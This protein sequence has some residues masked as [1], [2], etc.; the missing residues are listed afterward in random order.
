MKRLLFLVVMV[1]VFQSRVAA[2][3]GGQRSGGNEIVLTGESTLADY[4]SYAALHN[5]GLEAAFE[6]W[7]AA[8][9]VIPQAGA[10]PDPRFTF[11]Y[12]IQEVETRVGPQQRS[13]AV[14]QT[15]PWLGKLKSRGDAAARAADAAEQRYEAARLDLF[16][17]VKQAYYDYYYLARAVQIAEENVHLLTYLQDVT[18]T[19]FASGK[20]SHADAIKAQIELGKTE[21]LLRSLQDKQR[22]AAARLNAELNRP[23]DAG[24]PWPEHINDEEAVFSDEQ[25]F[26]WFHDSPR[27]KAADFDAESRKAEWS[28]AKKQIIPDLM[29]GLSVV[30]TGPA[31]MPGVEGSGKDPVIAS[32]SLNIPLWFGKYR[33][34]AR[35]KKAQYRVA[36]DQ[37]TDLENR[38]TSE[39]E[40]AL[41]GYRDA[42]RKEDL[43]GGSLIPK[44]RQHFE[45]TEQAYTGGTASLLDVIDAQRTLLDF[46]L[47]LERAKVD[48]AQRLAELEMRVGRELP[49]VENP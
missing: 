36:I 33:A 46:S 3:E 18:L 32:F 15:F 22:P 7:Q 4:L 44:A 27:L 8:L 25:V 6:R 9:A 31:R 10:L 37:R 17:R 38:L 1:L 47:A 39:L 23:P 43:Y 35:Q 28:L 19:A 48:R 34:E 5:P 26:A 29:L 45:A 42:E 21:D 14:S 20:G 11:S 40:A 24:L 12:Y 30:N 16:Y 49:R 41:F 2:Q 13:L